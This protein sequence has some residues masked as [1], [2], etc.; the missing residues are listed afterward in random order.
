MICLAACSSSAPSPTPPPGNAPVATPVAARDYGPPPQLAG[1]AA[2]QCELTAPRALPCI[3][4]LFAAYY[5]ANLGF[6]LDD[7]TAR[8]RIE[9]DEA[10][11]IH[12]TNCLGDR[13]FAYMRNIVAC[14]PQPGCAA[15]ATCVGQRTEPIK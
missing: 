12:M 6:D 14:W 7:A 2:A 15:F 10:A 1:D 4:E 8:K 13:D 9:R 5:R 3:D 11:T